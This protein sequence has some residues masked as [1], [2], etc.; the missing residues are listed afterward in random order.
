MRSQVRG[1]RRAHVDRRPLR[2]VE[3]GT[4][5]ASDLLA[6]VVPLAHEEIGLVPGPFARAPF[7]PGASDLPAAVLVLD[8]ELSEEARVITVVLA[9]V[10]VADVP[11]EPT[12][13]E[14]R[15]EHVL[16]RGERLRHVPRVIG[17][18]L[19]V[20][21]PSGR[22]EV[23]ANAGAIQVEVVDA[24]RARVEQRSTHGLLLRLEAPTQ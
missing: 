16:A 15:R 4:I 13:G 22:E 2:G 3:A 20:V 18:A 21:G 12:V 8:H 1:E 19:G 24:E 10:T 23:F 17:N 9:R 5:P 7:R 11:G 6:R 14:D